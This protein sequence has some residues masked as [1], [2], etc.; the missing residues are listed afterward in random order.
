MC[1][2]CGELA[3]EMSRCVR[4]HH[5]HY[6]GKECQTAAWQGHKKM[7]KQIVAEFAEREQMRGR[8]LFYH[9]LYLVDMLHV[10][11]TLPGVYCAR[12]YRS[13]RRRPQH[14]VAA[15]LGRRDRTVCYADA[16]YATHRRRCGA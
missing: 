11:T 4:C 13:Q 12:I 14:A 2:H 1:D 10:R 7:C 15:H 8:R 16:V 3:K 5:A 9:D 6:C